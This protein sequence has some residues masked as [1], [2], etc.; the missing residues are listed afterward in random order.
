ML[1]WYRRKHQPADG[2]TT[3]DVSSGVVQRGGLVD[4]L[5]GLQICLLR[6]GVAAAV[7]MS[8]VR[9]WGRRRVVSGPKKYEM[10]MGRELLLFA[11]LG[12]LIIS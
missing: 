10:M 8:M 11:S 1:T 3:G 5:E 6:R 9:R 12:H 7:E 4:G 2:R